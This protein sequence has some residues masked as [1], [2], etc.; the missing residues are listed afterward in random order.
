M[1]LD[2]EVGVRHSHPGSGV[3]RRRRIGQALLVDEG[4]QS[5]LRRPP[6]RLVGLAGEAQEGAQVTLGGRVTPALAVEGCEV[7]VRIRELRIDPHRAR[8]G[9][10]RARSLTA[11]EIGD[12][13]LHDATRATR[14][15]PAARGRRRPDSRHPPLRPLAPQIPQPIATRPRAGRDG[16][17]VV[18]EV[19]DALGVDP[20]ED[21]RPCRGGRGEEGQGQLEPTAHPP[22]FG[23]PGV[24]LDASQ[25]SL[26]ASPS[27]WPISGRTS[28]SIASWT[29]PRDPGRTTTTRPEAR[30]ARARDSTAADPISW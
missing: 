6:P 2:A 21:V 19:G 24:S 18:R 17:G 29:A 9:G 15:D 27:R 22:L 16:S 12:R 25:R 13:A 5:L 1:V 11:L 4:A 23:A 28:F 7:P 26:R 10:G 30:P 3:A 8:K 14:G 20:G